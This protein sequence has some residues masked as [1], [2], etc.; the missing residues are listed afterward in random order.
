MTYS[1]AR[2]EAAMA[3]NYTTPALE[4]VSGQGCK[5][6][7]TEGKEYLDLLAGIAVNALGHAHP[8]IVQ[9]VRDQIGQ[10]SHTSNLY[11]NEPALRL[12]ERLRDLTPGGHKAIFQSSGTEA[13]EGALKLVRRH[14]HKNGM[15]D[16]VVLSFEN[17][18]HGRTMGALTLT[19]QP[20]YHEGYAP[21]L[22][23]VHY[24]RY[25]DPAA[26]EAAFA[27][28]RVQGVF[29]ESVQGE[30]GVLPMDK[31][32]AATLGR[33]CAANNALL[34]ADEIQTGIGRT[35]TFYGYE[36]DGLKPDVVTVAKGLGGGLP[37]G[38]TI[39]HPRHAGLFEPGAHGTTFGGN[40]VACA[41]GNAVLDVLQ[42]DGLVA[43][44]GKLGERFMVEL[45]EQGC[46]V[47]VAARGRGLLVGMPLPGPFAP[48][49]IK[50]LR[51]KGYLV[52][53]A[54]KGVLRIAPPLVITEDELLGAVPHLVAAYK[55]AAKRAAPAR[56][57]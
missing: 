35:G 42:R 46:D 6:K 20:H 4:L 5:V 21:L 18:F 39:I 13:N 1:A 11:A 17:S 40:A 44:A 57:A 54:G 49:L 10:L 9:A 34:V 14:G 43:H 41:A 32:T 56:P 8:A 3:P 45:R 28:H 51:G 2:W 29:F 19:A 25:N 48:D 50:V 24:V 30:G 38:A 55:A 52:G 37:I 23:G 33:L 26:L 22:S 31:D 16:G 12:A 47:G 27:K 53:Q 7:D 15:G 36:H